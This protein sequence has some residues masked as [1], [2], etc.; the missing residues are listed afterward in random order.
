MF[1]GK[2]RSKEGKLSSAFRN[3]QITAMSCGKRHQ[4][5]SCLPSTP[6]KICSIH[7]LCYHEILKCLAVRMVVW[8]KL[9]VIELSRQKFQC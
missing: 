9:L 6:T 1:A 3:D 7:V 8:L 2:E 4:T 5:P